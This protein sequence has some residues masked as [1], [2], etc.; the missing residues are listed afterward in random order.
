MAL[1]RLITLTLHTRQ[2]HKVLLRA[3]RRA[4]ESANLNKAALMA[5]GPCYFLARGG[6]SMIV[7][8]HS[9]AGRQ[10]GRESASRALSMGKD[11]SSDGIL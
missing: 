2:A 1:T 10:V 4:E 9:T 7:F 11:L 6:E 5:V 8:R 3:F